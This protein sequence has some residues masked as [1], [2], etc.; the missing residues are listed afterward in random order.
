MRNIFLFCGMCGYIFIP[1][2]MVWPAWRLYDIAMMFLV[3]FTWR[4]ALSTGQLKVIYSEL[5]RSTQLA[6]DLAK[7]REESKRKSLFLNAISHDLRT[8]LNSI[9]LNASLAE[10]NAM[11]NDPVGLNRAVNEIKQS[12]RSTSLL[13]EGLLEYARMEHAP[14]VL[15]IEE[16]ELA[17]LLTEAANVCRRDVEERGLSLNVNTAGACR[18]RTDRLK[19]SRI[20]NN[21]LSNA[22]KFTRSG[23]IRIDVDR[24]HQNIELHVTDTGVG[25]AP[26][27]LERLFDEFF[28]VDN[29]ERDPNKGFGLGL[30]ISRRLARQMGGDLLVQSTYQRG[31]RFS[32][33]LPNVVVSSR[34]VGSDDGSTDGPINSPQQATV[35]G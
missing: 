19:L 9:T 27:N 5:G 24:T 25:I 35:A 7:S 16:F 23:S 14:E 12:V 20:L 13:L 18:V 11:Q 33:V 32:V 28:Q 17:E 34:R 21:L 31:S 4:Y 15:S 3:Y 30:A 8:P 22:V 2:K 6:E 26:E 1:I 29:H 10:M